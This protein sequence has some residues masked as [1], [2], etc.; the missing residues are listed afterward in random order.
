MLLVLYSEMLHWKSILAGCAS[1]SQEDPRT[2][3][4]LTLSWGEPPALSRGMGFSGRNLALLKQGNS[5]EQNSSSW[6]IPSFRWT[7]YLPVWPEAAPLLEVQTTVPQGATTT[8]H[9][10]FPANQVLFHS[11]HLWMRLELWFSNYALLCTGAQQ[12]SLGYKAEPQKFCCYKMC[13]NMYF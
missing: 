8:Q 4:Y 9:W 2:G 7:H 12:K 5:C 10:G 1:A 6:R 13:T 11:S 3:L